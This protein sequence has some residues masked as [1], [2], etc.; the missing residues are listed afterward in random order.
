MAQEEDFIGL[1]DD[2]A[3]WHVLCAGKRCGPYRLSDLV[4]AIRERLVDGDDLIWRLGWSD[5]RKVRFI[6]GRLSPSFADMFDC[7]R[8]AL[9]LV[10]PRRSILVHKLE[11]N[12]KDQN[13]TYDG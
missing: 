2:D 10:E 1:A 12:L 13:A 7:D 6:A 5:W 4:E 3:S 9:R 11:L 8:S